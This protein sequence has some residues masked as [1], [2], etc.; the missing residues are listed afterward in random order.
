MTKLIYHIIL[1][2]VLAVGT[3]FTGYSQ[4]TYE[5]KFYVGGHAG[6][7]L[8]RVNFS[9]SVPQ[10]FLIGKQVGITGRYAEESNFGLI[11]E[12]NLVQR[13][14]SEKFDEA[15]LTYQRTINYINIPI[16][17][18]IF[19]GSKKF[20][21]FFNLGPE[22]SFML[23]ESTSSNFDYSKPSSVVGFPQT[24]RSEQYGMSVST[25]FD[26]GISAGAGIE[27]IVAK[28]HSI[29][30]DGRF[31]YGLGNI[32]PSHKTDY[33]SASPNMSILVNIGYMIRVK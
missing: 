15:P 5:P 4:R 2:A 12:F 19:F 10:S 20:K 18:H 16:L 25:K 13:G 27:L 31:Y 8:S 33:F 28:K 30:L 22:V 21:A 24:H 11:A 1:Y 26:Y 23:G 17:T 14:W 7:S 29:M 9:P 6:V 32:F 3:I